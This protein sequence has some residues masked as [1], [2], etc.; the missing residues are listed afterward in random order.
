M[1]YPHGIGSD[2]QALGYQSPHDRDRGDGTANP[3][4]TGQLSNELE[5]IQVCVCFRC[6]VFRCNS[7]SSLSYQ[8]FFCVVLTIK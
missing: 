5:M 2:G 7:F 4:R 8:F 6:C 1:L 3:I